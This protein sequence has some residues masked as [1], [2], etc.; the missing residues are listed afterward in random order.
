MKLKMELKDLRKI[1]LEDFPDYD[2]RLIYGRGISKKSNLDES[3]ISKYAYFGRWYKIHDIPQMLVKDDRTI[4]DATGMPQEGSK[5]RIDS[6]CK[7]PVTLLKQRYKIITSRSPQS[8]D[9]IVLGDIGLSSVNFSVFVSD[10]LKVVL[11]VYDYYISNNDENAPD[12]DDFHKLFRNCFE[13]ISDKADTFRPYSGNARDQF[14]LRDY[15]KC[16]YDF[17]NRLLPDSM[18]VSEEKLITGNRKLTTDMLISSMKMLNSSDSE[19]VDT[20]LINLASS[21]YS[22]CRNVVGYLL[23]KYHLNS[24]KYLKNKST[25]VKWMVNMCGIDRYGYRGRSMMLGNEAEFA[26]DYLLKNSNGCMYY[27]DEPYRT[28]MHC[29]N[30]NFLTRNHDFIKKIHGL[31]YDL[32]TANLVANSL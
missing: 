8:P 9:F 6:S 19:M 31:S 3:C 20:A 29:D 5:L 18:F 1:K 24:V 23:S 28:E 27:T 13:D 26:K 25:A 22:E 15:S 32:S 2:V 4:S 17:Y 11:C 7:I 21:D 30:V 10:E 12:I 16:M 14:Y